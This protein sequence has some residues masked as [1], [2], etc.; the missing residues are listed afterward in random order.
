MLSIN[1]SPFD[2]HK[3]VLREHVM[4]QRAKEGKMQLLCQSSSWTR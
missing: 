3:P 1:A 4:A 2:M